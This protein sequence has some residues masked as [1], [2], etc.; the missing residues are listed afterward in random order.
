MI[1]TT[2]WPRLPSMAELS[3]RGELFN[4]ASHGAG[5]LL[6]AVGLFFL[7][8]PPAWRGDAAVALTLG[9]Y[10]ASL[11]AALLA[12]VVF[13]ASTGRA[14]RV[15]RRFDR[16]AIYVSMAG[17]YTPVLI[18]LLPAVWGVPVLALV[19]AL[20]VYGVLLEWIGSA[21]TER[22]SVN[23]YRV[24]GCISV[25]LLVPL[26]PVVGWFGITLVLVGG[27]LYG[28]GSVMVRLHVLRV[29]HQIWHVLV[30]AAA[31]THYAFMLL[32]VA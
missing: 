23:L 21:E 10:G 7:V 6:M 25:P 12:S 1:R 5:F 26:A 22:H 14:R 32:Y 13:H 20:A 19:W 28:L 31:G 3:E 9:L 2:T 30:L 29:N 24:L 15:L 8:V 17:S 27:L 18:V 16:S 4:V 11:L